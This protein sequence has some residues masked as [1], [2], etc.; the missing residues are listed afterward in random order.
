MI[1]L[2]THLLSRSRPH[3]HESARVV[4]NV[5]CLGG[6]EHHTS[7]HVQ[8]LEIEDIDPDRPF[9]DMLIDSG[10]PAAALGGLFVCDLDKKERLDR[11]EEIVPQRDGRADDKWIHEHSTLPFLDDDDAF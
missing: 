8:H 7:Y 3:Q 4:L 5:L 9:I 6:E 1:S 10:A 11:F 2:S